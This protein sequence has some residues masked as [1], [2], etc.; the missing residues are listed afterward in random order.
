[1]DWGD[2]FR[3]TFGF[4]A[5]GV[6]AYAWAVEPILIK[7]NRREIEIPNL[8]STL[9]GLK[10][11]HLSDLHVAGLGRI[12]R[13]LQRVLR[14]IEADICVITGDIVATMEGIPALGSLLEGFSPKYGIFGVLGNGEHDATMPGVE[15]AEYL[16]RLGIQ[17]LV[18][19]SAV[20]SI[21]GSKVQ[22]IGVDD[23][24][25]GLDD[26]EKAFANLEENGL[27]ILLAHSP[28]V[29]MNLK[30][31]NVDL[32]LAGHTHGGQIRLPILGVLWTHCRYNLHITS[33]YLEPDV[34]SSKVGRNIDARMYVS[35]G[36]S[37]SGIRARFMCR[38]EVAIHTLKP[39]ANDIC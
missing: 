10:I 4:L 19:Q 24:F 3:I 27:R 16:R 20:V 31:G 2:I 7:V 9:A 21:N 14:H 33:G 25:L 30:E 29:I 32:I 36:V 17:V 6:I 8:P 35:R 28:D 1:M 38:P 39:K 13:A 5:L 26:I 23:P 34:I 18:N 15:T 37:G 11:C 22:I 12:E